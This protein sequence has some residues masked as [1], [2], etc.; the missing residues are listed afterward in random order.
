MDCVMGSM[1]T[2]NERT[3]LEA[4]YRNTRDRVLSSL[5]VNKKTKV[6]VNS[7]IVYYVL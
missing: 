6:E 1:R 4:W 3:S 7:P 2:M 5:L